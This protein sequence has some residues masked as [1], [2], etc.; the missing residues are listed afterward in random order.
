MVRVVKAWD[1]LIEHSV[2]YIVVNL[3]DHNFVCIH[4]GLKIN[5]IGIM[6]NKITM[7]NKLFDTIIQFI[8]Q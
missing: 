1:L 2:T 3:N 7:K 8:I 6:S 5:N 4:A